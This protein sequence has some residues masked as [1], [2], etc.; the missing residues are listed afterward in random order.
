MTEGVNHNKAIIG[1][2]HGNLGFLIKHHELGYTFESENVPS[3]AN[4]IGQFIDKG[5]N[6]NQNSLEYQAR[7]KMSYFIESHKQLY[8]QWR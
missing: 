8:K 7:L 6:T 2:D 4:A 3:L 5:W 1:A